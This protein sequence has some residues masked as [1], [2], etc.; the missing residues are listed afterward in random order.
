MDAHLLDVDQ[1]IVDD[2]DGVPISCFRESLPTKPQ[3]PSQIVRKVTSP[4]RC[5]SLAIV[6]ISW[7]V[8]IVDGRVNQTIEIIPGQS[9]W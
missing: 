9:G 6:D 8:T 7:M 5:P 3:K 1:I 4:A 2:G